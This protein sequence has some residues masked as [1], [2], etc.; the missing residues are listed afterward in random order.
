MKES[1]RLKLPP[2][3]LYVLKKSMNVYFIKYI[4]IRMNVTIHGDVHSKKYILSKSQNEIDVFQ[5]LSEYSNAR[6]KT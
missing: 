5:D 4:I 6:I 2:N 3:S 1:V